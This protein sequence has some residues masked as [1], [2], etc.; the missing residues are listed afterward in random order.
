[1]LCSLLIVAFS[2]LLIVNVVARYAFSSPIFFAEELAVY[3]LV[4]MAFLAM[5]VA[6]HYDQH[7]RLT[8]LIGLLPTRWQ[9]FSYRLTELICLAVLATLLWYSVGW[10]RSPSV[11]YDIALTLDW[12][13]WHFY[14]IVPIF[15]VTG[16]L[17]ILA[18]LP[19][20]SRTAFVLANDDEET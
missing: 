6:V 11:T 18:R 5:S 17:H 15:C 1:M 14:L 20:R 4:W 13:K 8:M 2:V 10:I 9:R 7:V 3:I 12:P 19:D 16:I